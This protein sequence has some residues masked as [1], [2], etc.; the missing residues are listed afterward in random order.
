M[1]IAS[2]ATALTLVAITTAGTATSCQHA[3][4]PATVTHATRSPSTT[5]A[6]ATGEWIVTDSYFD[7]EFSRRTVICVNAGGN[8]R[9]ATA[10]QEIDVP[11]SRLNGPCPHGHVLDDGVL[12]N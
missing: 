2:T 9:I 5:D 3:T 8:L 6:S 1:R 10:W 11:G 4:P 12:G 7:P